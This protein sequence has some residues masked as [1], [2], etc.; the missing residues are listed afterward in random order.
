MG[1]SASRRTQRREPVAKIRMAQ[2]HNPLG[3]RQT[4]QLVSAKVG[5]PCVVGKE[6]DDEICCGA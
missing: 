2:L 5:Q 3:A 1:Y 6:V 4:A